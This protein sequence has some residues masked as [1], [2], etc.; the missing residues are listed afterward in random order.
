MP[1]ITLTLSFPQSVTWGDPVNPTPG[2]AVGWQQDSDGTLSFW[3]ID[4]T[5]ALSLQPMSGMVFTAFIPS[6]A[7]VK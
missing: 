4:Q 6:S 5:G 7:T 2:T 3:V 1:E